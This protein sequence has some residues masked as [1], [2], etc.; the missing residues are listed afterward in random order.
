MLFLVITVIWKIYKAFGIAMSVEEDLRLHCMSLNKSGDLIM[1]LMVGKKCSFII[2]AL[3]IQWVPVLLSYESNKKAKLIE[4]LPTWQRVNIF[5]LLSLYA[6]YKW[7][8][9]NYGSFFCHFI[10]I[11]T[12]LIIAFFVIPLSITSFMYL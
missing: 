5:S 11:K 9:Y 3:T 4:R 12:H 2:P 6:C 10:I 8:K 1:K 7:K